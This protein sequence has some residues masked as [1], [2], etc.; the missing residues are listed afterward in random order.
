M[1]R[2]Q[3]GQG[4]TDPK[5][6]REAVSEMSRMARAFLYRYREAG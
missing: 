2:P 1:T 5:D 4:M 3:G 6:I